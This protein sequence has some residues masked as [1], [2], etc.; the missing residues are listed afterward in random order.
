MEYILK[1]YISTVIE[2]FKLLPVLFFLSIEPFFY[3]LSF[4]LGVGLLF[5]DR[6][7]VQFERSITFS[8]NFFDKGLRSIPLYLLSFIL[9]LVGMGVCALIITMLQPSRRAPVPIIIGG[10]AFSVAFYF[11]LQGN[12]IYWLTKLCIKI[13][14]NTP[15]LTFPVILNPFKDDKN[16]ILAWLLSGLLPFVI[17]SWAIYIVVMTIFMLI[18]YFFWVVTCYKNVYP[19]LSDVKVF[20]ILSS[21]YLLIISGLSYVIK[22]FT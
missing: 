12:F 16:Y 2:F 18:S 6:L 19:H 11:W 15:A 17:V 7:I 9:I 21:I 5:G 3:I 22:V 14:T 1:L 8:F 13:N 20:S 10:Y 4:V